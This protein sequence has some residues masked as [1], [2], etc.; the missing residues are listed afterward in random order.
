MRITK[1]PWQFSMAVFVVS[2]IALFAAAQPPEHVSIPLSSIIS[3]NPQ[4]GMRQLID[5][6]PAGD[7][8]E[9]QKKFAGFNSNAS[10][11]FLVDAN[12][13]RAAISAS[14]R[15]WFGPRSPATSKSGN[16]WLVAFLGI[17][18]SGPR[19]YEVT[20]VDVVGDKVRLSYRTPQPSMASKDVQQYFFWVPLGKLK[21]GVYYVELYDE[22]LKAA[23]LSRRVEVLLEKIETKRGELK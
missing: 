14:V 21:P 7:G 8:K 18:P 1:T 16:Q 12:S 13:E 19:W 3:T 22:G 17:G 2:I 11:V 5:A 23:V 15:I 6:F 20:N 9:Y 4:N 10:N